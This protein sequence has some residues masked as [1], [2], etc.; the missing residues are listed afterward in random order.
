MG[1]GT[2]RALVNVE[3]ALLQVGDTFDIDGT[4]ISFTIGE[5]GSRWVRLNAWNVELDGGFTAKV[6][7][8]E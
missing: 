6:S 4:D 2:P 8:P 5:T 1:G 7:M 3:G